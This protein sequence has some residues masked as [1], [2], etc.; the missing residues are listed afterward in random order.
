MTSSEPDWE[1]CQIEVR[2]VHDGR[3]HSAYS[4]APPNYWLKFI[5]NARTNHGNFVAGVSEKIPIPSTV[6]I[7]NDPKPIKN[8]HQ[9]F[10]DMLLAQLKQEG[11]EVT[12]RNPSRWWDIQLQR[13]AQPKPSF[14]ERIKSFLR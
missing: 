2:V 9:N 7:V 8:Q 13:P 11:W 10:L 1:Y 12:G 14:V 5:A 6:F 3:G 4:G